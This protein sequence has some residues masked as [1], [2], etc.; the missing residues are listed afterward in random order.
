MTT[1]IELLRPHGLVH[2][3]AFSHV[4]VIPPGATQILVGGQNGVNGEGQLVADDVVAQVE[5]TM[6]NV[7]TALEA[8]GATTA[9]LVSMTVFLVEGAD[10]QAGYAAAA[11]QL[12]VGE[13][14]PLVTAAIVSALGVPGALVEVAAVAA[15]VR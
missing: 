3:P 1:S 9:D 5:Q 6:A 13:G 12:P 11:R 10:L 7:R 8:A 4:A 14:A 2:S 15:V